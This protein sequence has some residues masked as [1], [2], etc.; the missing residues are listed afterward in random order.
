[1]VTKESERSHPGATYEDLAEV[2]DKTAKHVARD[3]PDIDWEDIRQELVVFVLQYGKSIKLHEY[4]GN[5]RWLLERVAQ[6]YC[7]N[8]RAQHMVLTPQYAYKPSDIKLILETAFLGTPRSGYVPDDARSPLSRTF[9]V[10]DSASSF[11]VQDIDP[12][13]EADFL[14]VSSDVKASIKKLKPELRLSLFNRYVMGI[15]PD[16][17]SYE[18]KRLN[19]A[20]NELTRRL[21]WYRGIDKDRRPVYSNARSRAVITEVYDG[22]AY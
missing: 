7:K 11:D 17:D 14:E 16:N 10:Y 21:N 2:I 5:P 4:G 1:M 20:V 19:K 9:N 6:E 18:R 8:M 3:Y 13:H 15:I 12:F 22:N